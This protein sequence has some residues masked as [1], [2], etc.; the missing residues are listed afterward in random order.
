MSVPYIAHVSKR[1]PV[2]FGQTRRSIGV[3]EAP[4]EPMFIGEAT[5]VGQDEHGVAVWTLR[6]GGQPIA[7]RWVMVNRQFIRVQ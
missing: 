1:G 4:D 2:K 7:G 6:I 3:F 5:L